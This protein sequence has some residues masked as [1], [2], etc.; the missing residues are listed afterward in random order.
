MTII[1]FFLSLAIEPAVNVLAKKGWRRGSATGLVL[2][3]V[4]AGTILFFAAFGSV[5]V[6][7]ASELIDDTPKYVRNV[8][9]F[10]NDDFGFDIDARDLIRDIESEDGAV[11]ELES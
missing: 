8:V 2:G 10:L 1:A 9:N 5:A 7:Q 4:L 11:R 6:T 3:A